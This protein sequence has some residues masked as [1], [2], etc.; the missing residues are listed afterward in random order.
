VPTASRVC[1]TCY[2]HSNMLPVSIGLQQR[3]QRTHLQQAT[4]RPA[5]MPAN[6]AQSMCLQQQPSEA[7]NCQYLGSKT[8]CSYV[9]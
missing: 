9:Y 5:Q 3:M 6:H 2:E 1:S 4:H 7:V 8:A